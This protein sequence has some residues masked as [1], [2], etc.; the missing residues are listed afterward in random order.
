M[1]N[2]TWF[3]MYSEFATDPVVQTLAFEDQRHY[4]MILCFKCS[5][6]LDRNISPK[7][8]NRIILRGIGLDSVA[9]DEARRRLMDVGLI[10]KNWQPKSWDKRQFISDNSTS[11]VRKHRN[12]KETSNV[13]ETD[14]IQMQKNINNTPSVSPPSKTRGSRQAPADFQVTED[15]VQWAKTECPDVEI[16]AE[17]EAFRDHEFSKPYTKW[18]G[19]WRNWMRKAQRFA[20]QRGKR[21][22]PNQQAQ[23]NP[24]ERVRQAF[25][26]RE[27]GG[28]GLDRRGPDVR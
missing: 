2:Y 6:I 28:D 10:D 26:D 3:R 12:N 1:N 17:T 20:K 13:S 19:V 14:Q 24:V 27:S 4:I 11:R 16:H 9:G 15:L 25:A 5:G 18:P 23:P 22:E 21:N 8:R 7:E